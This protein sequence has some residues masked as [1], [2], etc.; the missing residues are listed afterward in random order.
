MTVSETGYS[1]GDRPVR[2]VELGTAPGPVLTLLTL[3]ATV[4][5]LHLT[6]GDGL[7]RNVVLG[8]PRPA[9]YLASRQYLGGTIGR[10][11]N[12]I[13]RGTFPLDGRTVQLETHDRGNHLHGGPGGFDHQLWDI[14]EHDANSVRFSHH[15][16]D[17]H[18]G[19]PGNVAAY[20]SFA[21]TEAG[22]RIDLGATTD[23]PTV[24][25]MTSHA[26]FNLDGNGAGTIDHH[27]LSVAADRYTPVDRTGIPLG[28][29]APVDGTAFDFRVA[30]PLADAVR[31]GEDQV[32]WARGIDH[33]FVLDSGSELPA[34][35]LVS[36]RTATRLE[37]FTDQPGL[38]VYTGNSFDGRTPAST[39]G[40]YRQGDGIALE[41]Q[42]FP[43]TPNR[44]DFGSAVLRP[45]E[46]YRARIEWRFGAIGDET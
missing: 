33:N 34:A 20:A 1:I 15:S 2:R 36:E 21:V 24:V 39:G 23:A 43:D 14:E 8:L 29:H 31:S 28:E 37:V 32:A 17:G 11:A 6:G 25:N 35:T 22:V 7:R 13:A 18:M 16:P 46:R 41:P 4:E 10:Y 3:G 26:Y 19:Y 38:Q 30:R 9:D 42:L 44:A 27:L 40:Y 45:G 12:R 5:A